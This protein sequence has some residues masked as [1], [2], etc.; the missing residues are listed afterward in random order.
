MTQK[1]K[2]IN[3]NYQQIK[4][5]ITLR[6]NSFKNDHKGEDFKQQKL[7]LDFDSVSEKSKKND[8]NDDEHDDYYK[9][10]FR[11]MARQNRNRMTEAANQRHLKSSTISGTSNNL[12]NCILIFKIN[13]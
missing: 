10:Q 7:N 5:K 13:S 9:R 6:E 1:T 8:I 11:Q 2:Q 4:D 12:H 3:N